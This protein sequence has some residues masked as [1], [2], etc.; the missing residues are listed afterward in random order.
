MINMNPK[1][2]EILHDGSVGP[3]AKFRCKVC[4]IIW[5]PNIKPDSGGEFYRG[6]WQYAFFRFKVTPTNQ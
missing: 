3:S 2:V 5:Y 6:A 1:I 4:G